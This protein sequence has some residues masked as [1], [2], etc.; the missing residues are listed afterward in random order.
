[1]PRERG[2]SLLIVDDDEVDVRA[3]TRSLGRHAPEMSIMVAGDGQEALDVLR[4]RGTEPPTWPYLVLLDLNMPR[5]NG[6]EF[7]AALRDDPALASTVVIVLTTSSDEGDKRRAYRRH[8]AGYVVKSADD[9]RLQRLLALIDGYR[10][11][12]SFP[13]SA[14]TPTRAS[15]PT[16]T[17][18][19]TPPPDPSSQP[20]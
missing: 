8:V 19:P 13:Q 14:P 11:I 18:T 17:S 3:L 12:V 5:M 16:R 15:T 10:S 2:L 6:H 9:T 1:M 4:G 20:V 7:L